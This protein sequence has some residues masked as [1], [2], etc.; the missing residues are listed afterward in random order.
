[1]NLFS[2]VILSQAPPIQA[3][4]NAGEQ[5][6]SYPDQDRRT[7][8]EQNPVTIHNIFPAGLLLFNYRCRIGITLLIFSFF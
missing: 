8:C 4:R 5:H 7:A 3:L 2:L 1:M 6:N